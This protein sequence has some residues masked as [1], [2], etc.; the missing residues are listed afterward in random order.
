V[1]LFGS[2]LSILVCLFTASTRRVLEERIMKAHEWMESALG[3]GSDVVPSEGICI[4]ILPTSISELLDNKVASLTYG[5]SSGELSA[6]R[7]RIIPR[8]DLSHR[9]P[10][11]YAGRVMM[12]GIQHIQVVGDVLLVAFTKT[13]AMGVIG[14]LT[15]E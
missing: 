13:S 14:V 3:K 10:Q 11:L 15:H 12:S 1:F 2:V 6:P 5:I 7:L 9:P 8:I 4:V